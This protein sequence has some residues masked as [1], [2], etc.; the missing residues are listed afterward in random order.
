[1]KS[2]VFV[3]PNLKVFIFGA[4][5]LLVVQHL[6]TNVHSQATQS[7][8]LI[9]NAREATDRDLQELINRAVEAPSTELYLR[10]SHCFEKKGDYRRALYFMRRADQMSHLDPGD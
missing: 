8:P 2:T 1:M 9:L 10:I 4:I 7:K 6:M 3:R 5:L